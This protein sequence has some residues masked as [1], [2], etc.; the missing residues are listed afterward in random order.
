M[1][2]YKIVKIIQLIN[3]NKSL[4]GKY[5]YS[6]L[7]SCANFFPAFRMNMETYRES[8]RIHAECGVIRARP[9]PNVNTFHEIEVRTL[10]RYFDICLQ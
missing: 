8:P 9:I 7:F 6:E 10:L 5:P 4:C 2:V 3:T 1:L